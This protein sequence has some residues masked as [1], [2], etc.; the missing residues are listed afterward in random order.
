MYS[1]K[2]KS[3]Q[4]TLKLFIKSKKMKYCSNDNFS[5]YNRISYIFNVKQKYNKAIEYADKGIN[6]NEFDS[7]A[8]YV[9][10]FALYNLKHF[11]IALI[12]LH[13]AEK[14][15]EKNSDLYSKISYI[16]SLKEKFETALK[17]AE[18]AI[19]DDDKDTTAIYR[20]GYALAKLD[21]YNDALVW[22]QK[23]NELGL[24]LIY[25]ELND[26]INYCKTQIE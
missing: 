14:L 3:Y 20:K 19:L 2:L 15:G 4:E 26:E 12:M 5:L 13:K 7:Y 9:K 16:Y 17:Y 24:G 10:G 23:A 21:R 22:L 1:I 6:I 11:D 25:N 8:Y 18:M